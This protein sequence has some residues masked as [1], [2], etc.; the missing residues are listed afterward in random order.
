VNVMLADL[1]SGVDSSTADRSTLGIPP[2]RRTKLRSWSA[3]PGSQQRF[4]SIQ[5]TYSGWKGP[6]QKTHPQ[7]SHQLRTKQ[8]PAVSFRGEIQRPC[9][10]GQPEPH[11]RGTALSTPQRRI[12][13]QGVE[14]LGHA[15]VSSTICLIAFK[16]AIRF[17]IL[18]YPSAWRLRLMSSGGWMNMPV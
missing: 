3:G 15:R 17:R 14:A 9:P 7:A 10:K 12:M 1:M 5:P 16:G 2:K 11:H 4:A 8:F 6:C 13:Y 18:T